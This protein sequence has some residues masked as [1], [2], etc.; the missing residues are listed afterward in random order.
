MN[1]TGIVYEAPAIR[2]TQCL[3]PPSIVVRSGASLN[4]EQWTMFM[5]HSSELQSHKLLQASKRIVFAGPSPNESE[6]MEMCQE[7]WSTG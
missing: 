2:G 3:G 1:E 5:K 4:N 6:A 7:P